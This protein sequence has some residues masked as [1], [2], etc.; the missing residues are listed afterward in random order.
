MTEPAMWWL[1]H[2]A[3]KPFEFPQGKHWPVVVR[4]FW[5]LLSTPVV[6]V[7]LVI[8]FPLVMFEL[9]IDMVREFK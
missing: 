2:V 9:I 6:V 5:L 8:G 3:F 7:L 4:F 1:D